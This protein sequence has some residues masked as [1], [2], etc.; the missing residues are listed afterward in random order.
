MLYLRVWTA[1]V[2]VPL[3]MLVFSYG[4]FWPTFGVIGAATAL[5]LREYVRMAVPGPAVHQLLAALAGLV[6]FAGVG[7]SGRIGAVVP[8]WP[9]Q[10]HTGVMGVAVATLLLQ[11]WYTLSAEA[12]D[13]HPA[14]E[15]MSRGVFGM[16][17]IGV[18]AGFLQLM[19]GLEGPGWR[20][21]SLLYLTLSLS[22]LNDTSAYFAGHAFGRTPFAPKISPKKSWEGFVGGAAG[23]AAAAVIC[24]FVTGLHAVMPWW[25]VAL[26]CAA[27]GA[28]GPVGD[29]GESLVKRCTNTKDAGSVLPG[30]GGMLDRLDAV[31]FNAPI[32]YTVAVLT[33]PF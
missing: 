24:V 16:L 18:L 32:V 22:W 3:I 11:G 29:L 15:R 33:L 2:L 9:P 7:L 1:V 12:D 10:L 6:V 14:F 8:G 27:C 19:Y 25:A 21:S 30:H 26:L 13:L 17:Y 4:G 5:M 23:G 28:W 20:G 31:M